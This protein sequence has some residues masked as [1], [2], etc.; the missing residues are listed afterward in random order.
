MSPRSVRIAPAAIVATVVE[1]VLFV[2]RMGQP[3]FEKDGRD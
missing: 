3:G 1:F 2:A